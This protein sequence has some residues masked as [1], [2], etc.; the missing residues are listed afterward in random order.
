VVVCAMLVL[1]I[2]LYQLQ[3]LR[4]EVYVVQSIA[5]FRKTLFVPADRGLIKD[6]KVARWW[7]T[8]LLRRVPHPAFCKAR[9][10]TRSWRSS[11]PICSWGPKTSSDQDDYQKSWLSKDKLERFKRSGDARHSRDQVTSGGELLQDLVALLALAESRGE[12]HVEGGPVLHQRATFWSLISPRSAGTNR[13][14]RK[15]AIDC[16]T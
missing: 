9:S 5:N 10:A 8:G 15:L 1:V 16:T 12:E 11:P 6:Q 13:V 7:R 14:L 3:I 2:R 4:G